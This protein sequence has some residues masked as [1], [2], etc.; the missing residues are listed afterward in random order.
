M[1]PKVLMDK[2]FEYDPTYHTV[3]K[4]KEFSKEI[5]EGY[6]NLKSI[7]DQAIQ[8]ID[9]WFT[10][11]KKEK[12]D[13][14]SDVL[15]MQDGLWMYDEEHHYEWQSNQDNYIVKLYPRGT[16]MYFKM[17]PI[18]KRYFVCDEYDGF[19]NRW[20]DFRERLDL[21]NF[22]IQENENMQPVTGGKNQSMYM[23]LKLE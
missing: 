5:R 18:E 16:I 11:L 3:L 4:S 12:A 15:M 22:D 1:L 20:T 19:F 21:L 9:K 23:W 14:C 17:L 13:W 6:F 2:I 8:M 7:Q 10:T